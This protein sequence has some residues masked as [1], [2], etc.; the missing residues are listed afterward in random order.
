MADTEPNKPDTTEPVATTPDKQPATE[1]NKPATKKKAV[2]H[3]HPRGSNT[4]FLFITFLIALVACGGVYY[5]WEQ[6]QQ[7]AVR[8]QLTITQLEQKLSQ[9]TQQQQQQGAQ[10]AQSLTDINASQEALRRNLTN[11]IRDNEHLRNDWLLAEAEYLIKLA[12]HRI[13]L[14]K[15]VETA[16]VALKA[17][18]ARLAEVGDPALLN[19]R[20]ALAS[21]IQALANVPRID[22]AGIS[23]TLSALNS[24]ISNLP[25]R[26]P[27]PASK[28]QQQ[29]TSSGEHSVQNWKDLP[30]AIWQDLKGLVV[31]RNHAKPIEPLLSPEQ[32]FFLTQN[33]ELLLEQS[34]LALL[35]GHSAVYQERLAAAKRWI[36]LFFDEDHN[37]TRNMLSTLDTL[38]AINIAP[39]LPDI[40]AT[41]SAIQKY[42]L[43][44]KSDAINKAPTAEKNKP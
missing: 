25:L 29:E 12:N 38:A 27:D 5:L 26:T 41:Y 16:M 30:A 4:G 35:N 2:H 10:L 37:V 18:D 40:S 42:R 19:V 22:I 20:Q 9:L 32:H 39:T 3:K 13:I 33:L 36:K 31:I 14:E 21:D 1:N 17:A 11:L 7:G 6:L 43:R 44:G 28:K 34:R 15:D 8:Q 23:V 24:N